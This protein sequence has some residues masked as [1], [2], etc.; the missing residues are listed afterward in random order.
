MTERWVYVIAVPSILADDPELWEQLSAAWDQGG[1]GRDGIRQMHEQRAL[2]MPHRE[3]AH[4][5]ALPRYLA[6]V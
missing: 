4:K 6:K 1:M 3:Y 5:I 2:G